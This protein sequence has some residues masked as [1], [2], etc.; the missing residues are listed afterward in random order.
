MHVAAVAV[1]D[2]RGAHRFGG[3]L[4]LAAVEAAEA[5]QVALEGAAKI[6]QVGEEGVFGGIGRAVIVAVAGTASQQ[7][8][9]GAPDLA[10][11]V[12]VGGRFEQGQ[13]PWAMTE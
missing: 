12:G 5:P 11:A 8:A 2:A 3:A 1:V 6:P 10:V 4:H 7:V 13:R 9:D